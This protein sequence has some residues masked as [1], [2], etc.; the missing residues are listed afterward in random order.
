MPQRMATCLGYCAGKGDMWWG[1]K[2]SFEAVGD[3]VWEGDLGSRG[4]IVILTGFRVG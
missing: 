2:S 4:A 1:M 3:G